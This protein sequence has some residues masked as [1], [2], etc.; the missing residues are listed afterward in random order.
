MISKELYGQGLVGVLELRD[1]TFAGLGF[2]GAF[3]RLHEHVGDPSD[4]VSIKTRSSSGIAKHR[5]PRRRWGRK[6]RIQ[7]PTRETL[8]RWVATACV[9]VVHQ[10][11]PFVG[12]GR[13]RL[14]R[15]IIKKAVSRTC[16]KRPTS[17]RIIT[18]TNG[19]G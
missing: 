7:E 8:H 19:T 1:S 18:G 15:V 3:D 12:V 10:Q 2:D 6:E 13:G 16:L 5:D 17:T 9:G 4:Q 14:G 11:S